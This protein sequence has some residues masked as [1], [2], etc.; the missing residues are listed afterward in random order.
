MSNEYALQ[1]INLSKFI[2]FS[3]LLIGFNILNQQ[4]NLIT[5]GQGLW[6]SP[7]WSS[8]QIDWLFTM[9]LF[10]AH[11]VNP[12]TWIYIILNQNVQVDSLHCITHIL[13]TL[14]CIYFHTYIYTCIYIYIY[15]H[16]ICVYAYICISICVCILCVWY[17]YMYMYIYTYIHICGSIYLDFSMDQLPFYTLRHVYMWYTYMYIFKFH[18]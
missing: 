8:M 6:N 3:I 16:I 10:L 18:V 2:L 12:F 11:N 4:N 7:H 17:T 13:Y 5:K 9:Y 14:Y 15:L 1:E